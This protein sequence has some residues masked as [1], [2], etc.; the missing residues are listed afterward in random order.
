M[1]SSLESSRPSR[2]RQLVRGGLAAVL[3]R[4][5]F[6][7]RGS[8]RSRSVCLTFDDGPHPEHTPRVLDVLKAERLR[9]TFFVVGREAERHPEVVRRIVA[10]GHEL[11][12]HS[13]FHGA[14]SRT[15]PGQLMDEVRRTRDVLARVAGRSP[16]LFRPPHGKLTS[17]KLL[18]LWQGGLTVVLWNVDP[19]DCYCQ[20][21][22]ELRD[23]FQARP[24]RGGDVVLMH[25]NKP[26]GAAVLSELIRETRRRGLA[27]ATPLDWLGRPAARAEGSSRDG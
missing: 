19:K 17:G 22:E 14:P 24:L 23:W 2:L 8:P 21:P 11:G 1:L 26:H 6:L 20:G 9:A 25:D 16:T 7:V 4:R 27:F 15:S 13:Y 18:R 3:P 5:W 12:H 10:E